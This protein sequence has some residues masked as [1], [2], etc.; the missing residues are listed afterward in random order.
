MTGILRRQAIRWSR[1]EE[2]GDMPEALYEALAEGAAS[3]FEKRIIINLA[4][5]STIVSK[6]PSHITGIRPYDEFSR[7]WEYSHSVY[8]HTDNCELCNARIKENCVLENKETGGSILIG[9]VCVNRYIE[10]RDSSGRV[11]SG[12]EKK[13][14]LKTQMTEAKKEFLRQDFAQRYPTALRDL[15][16]WEQFMAGK[17]WSRYRSLH[18]TVVKRLATHGYLGPKTMKEWEKFHETAE[19]EYEAWL[20]REEQRKLTQRARIEQAQGQRIDFA[21]KLRERR[22]QFNKEA[23]EFVG[24]VARAKEMKTFS[25]WEE[26]MNSRIETKIRGVGVAGLTKGYRAYYDGLL[27]T[28]GDRKPNEEDYPPNAKKLIALRD[29]GKLNTWEQ[30]FVRSVIPL[31]VR[32]QSPSAKQASII[33][34]LVKRKL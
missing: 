3:K 16:R 18:S 8:G 11:L 1:Q 28:T 9:N 13:E 6:D 26:S 17:K 30:N 25:E 23:D 7:D 24:L 29:A 20:H 33:T 27:Y 31:L 21:M 10:I 34:R 14:Y 2:K 12:E 4:K 19:E 32:K 22:N 5:I 15:K